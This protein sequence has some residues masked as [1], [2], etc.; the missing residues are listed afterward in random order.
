MAKL[1]KAAQDEIAAAV[2]I[3]REDGVHIHKTYAQ[4]QESLKN[5]P[6]VEEPPEDEPGEGDPPP[7][8]DKK[9]EPEPPV[10]KSM[11]WG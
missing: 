4:F 7:K 8:K 11:W 5:P 9:N 2:R 6:K 3:L 1:S 10:K